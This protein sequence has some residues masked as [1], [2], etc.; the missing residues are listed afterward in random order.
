[1]ARAYAEEMLDV[2][3]DPTPAKRLQNSTTQPG[4]FVAVVQEDST[5][6]S[7]KLLLGQ[8]NCITGRQRASLI[9][10]KKI[11]KGLY[12][13]ELNGEEWTESLVS[14]VP[15][16]VKAAKNRP[17]VFRLAD[18]PRTIHRAAFENE[19]QSPSLLEIIFCCLPVLCFVMLRG[20]DGGVSNS[21]KQGGEIRTVICLPCQRISYY[22]LIFFNVI[23]VELSLFVFQTEPSDGIPVNDH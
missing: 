17:G 12:K 20:V 8:V 7:P 6:Q 16:T 18:S 14:L 11:S 21:V 22:L 15:V 4:D 23:G 9:W 5:L 2:E 3:D 13:L 1:M 19:V 10:Y